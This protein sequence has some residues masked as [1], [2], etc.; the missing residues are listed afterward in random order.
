MGRNK[1][2][3]FKENEENRN[4]IQSGKP[5]FE[6]IK[7]KWNIDQF[8][9]QN[10]VVVELAC[11]RGEFTVGLAREY[12]DQ[13]FIGVDIK[14][15]RIWKGSKTAIEEGLDNVA[16]LRTQI[17]HLSEFFDA[18]EISEL[19]ITFPD[20]FPRDGDEKRRLTSPRFLDMYKPLIKKDGVVNFKTDNTGLFDY[21][22]ELVR[23][24]EDIEVIHYTHDFY[25]S[26]WKEDHHGIK[27]RYEKI[28]SDKGEKIKYLK[29]SF[30]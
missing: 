20:P 27:T 1:L 29:F 2:Q 14:G 21:T 12:R 5:I 6:N 26:E 18:E 15:S 13:N 24:R 30:K 8:Q 17:Q 16:F 19:W 7:G 25:Q 4:V 22:L 10:P 23:S 11:G 28:F 3:R 9:N